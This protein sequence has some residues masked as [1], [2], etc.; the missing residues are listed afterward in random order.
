[1][2]SLTSNG[3]KLPILIIIIKKEPVIMKDQIDLGQFEV[4][5]IKNNHKI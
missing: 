4:T 5:V 1:M 2:A 3:E